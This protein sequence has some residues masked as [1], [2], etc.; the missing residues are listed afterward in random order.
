METFTVAEDVSP[1][2]PTIS[3]GL[4]VEGHVSADHRI[5]SLALCARK[6][7]VAYLRWRAHRLLCGGGKVLPALWTGPY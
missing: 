3:G 6:R 2:P 5:T 4:N 1:A 7:G